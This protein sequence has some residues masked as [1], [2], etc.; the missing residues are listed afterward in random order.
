MVERIVEYKNKHR[1]GWREYACGIESLSAEQ[2]D[3]E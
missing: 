1:K 2:A 3:V